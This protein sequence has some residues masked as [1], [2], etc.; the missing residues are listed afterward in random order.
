MADARAAP[1]RGPQTG[2]HVI[3]YL[4]LLLVLAACGDETAP[5]FTVGTPEELALAEELASSE[6]D[7][8][9]ASSPGTIGREFSVVRSRVDELQMAHVRF[10][11]QHDGVP[12]FGGE[13]I[14]HLHSDGA[15][16][17]FTDALLR[18]LDVDTQPLYD[19]DEAVEIAVSESV[20]WSAL[21]D[22]PQVDLWVLRHDGDHL[23][24]RVRLDR[25]DGTHATSQPVLFVDAHAGEVVWAYEGLRT[26]TGTAA[27]H[28]D[29]TVSFDTY[30]SGGSYYLEDTT[31]DLGTLSYNNSTRRP[32][33]LTDSD[34]DWSASTQ[35]SAAS[36]HWTSTKVWDYY[37]GTFGRS[38]L[39]GS[40]GPGYASSNTGSGAVITSYTDYSR[41]YV[42]AYWS[43][44]YMVYG[45]GDGVNAGPLVT[46]DITGH[47]MTHGVTESEANF[48]YS[49]ESGGIDESMADVFGAMVER[50][51]D[52]A[53]ANVWI[54]GED[55]WTPSTAGDGLRY[56]DSP[57]DDGVSYDYYTSSIGSADVHY[58]SGVGNLA[59]YLLAEGGAH[60]TRGGTAL[61]AI[62]A[63]TAAAIW[64]R[65]LTTYLTSSS[66]YSALRTATL[67]AATDLYGAT[68]AEYT[69]VGD[70]WTTVGVGASS[71]GGG[72][73]DC[74]GYESS[75][76]GTLSASGSAAYISS[77]SGFSAASGTL[78]GYM[79]GPSSANFDLYL[80]KKGKKVWST[81][82]SDTSS[83]S[84]GTVSYAGSSGTYRWVVYSASGSGSYTLCYDTP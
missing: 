48:V 80:Q 9:L 41:N 15:V 34:N 70:A 36:A 46:L 32:S 13:A 72:G 24:W 3:R 67:S 83:S 37:S 68:S 42:N 66:N 30:L 78:L 4:P 53:N 75:A 10:Q 73:T 7:S 57:A 28:Y 84:N 31:R 62:G 6:L 17:G 20:G 69:A 65:A 14:V 77:S 56:M 55:C 5:L 25:Q 60:P 38:G 21:T 59:F 12:V 81:V 26:A 58:S 23:A 18:D 11:Q 29:G 71:G 27:S 16:R 43:G 50:S 79:E 51:V 1:Y 82:A 2:A 74:T 61:T 63:D 35:T 39:D 8:E 64:Y 45:D 49:G 47:E 76:S 22:D 40:G 54:V 33:W 44:S 19:A 52:G